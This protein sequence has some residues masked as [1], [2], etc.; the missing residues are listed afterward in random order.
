MNAGMII[1]CLISFVVGIIG[2]AQVFWSMMMAKKRGRFLTIGTSLAWTL[3]L[4]GT[5]F[6]VYK[7]APEQF[8]N[9]V[10]TYIATFSVVLISQLLK[11]IGR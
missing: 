11:K 8:G 9:L 1:V 10:W 3:I 2:F 5:A 6:A 4:L 7:I